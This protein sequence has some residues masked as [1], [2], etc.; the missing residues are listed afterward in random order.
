MPLPLLGLAASALGGVAKKLAGKALKAATKGK[1]LGSG[2]GKEL[3]KTAAKGAVG[4]AGT[5]IITRS[6][7]SVPMGLPSTLPEMTEYQGGRR[8]RVNSDGTREWAKPYRRMN[9]MNVRALRKAVRRIGSAE[10]LLKSIFT[11]SGGK[12]TVRTKRRAR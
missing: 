10:K 11:I 2:G 1:L 4:I 8:V 9:P 6:V 5:A 3:L 12:V 7:N